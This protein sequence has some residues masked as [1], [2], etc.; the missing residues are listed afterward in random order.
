MLNKNAKKWVAALRSGEYTQ[1]TGRLHIKGDG[2]CCLGVACDLYQ[3]E[4]GDLEVKTRTHGPVGVEEILYDGSHG[5]LAG[6][7]VHWLGL[8]SPQGSFEDPNGSD[9]DSDD[10][11]LTNANDR[12]D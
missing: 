2:Y 4:V 12:G 11:S 7:V 6:K 3:K 1:C 5:V 8:N 9:N 10:D